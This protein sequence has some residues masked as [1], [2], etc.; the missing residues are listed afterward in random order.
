MECA[1]NLIFDDDHQRLLVIIHAVHGE[2]L[3]LQVA[4]TAKCRL[5]SR[6]PTRRLDRFGVMPHRGGIIAA[7]SQPVL[8]GRDAVLAQALL[9]LNM[10]PIRVR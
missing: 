2:L 1:L 4:F 5:P 8:L 3:D 6:L 10:Q 9:V 7:V